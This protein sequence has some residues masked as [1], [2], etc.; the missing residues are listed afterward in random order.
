MYSLKFAF[1]LLRPSVD[2]ALQVFVKEYHPSVYKAS[3][4]KEGLSLF[5]G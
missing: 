1:L 2:S 4:G 5:G 3:S